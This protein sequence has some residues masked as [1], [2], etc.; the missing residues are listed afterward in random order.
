MNDSAAETSVVARLATDAA[1]ARRLSDGLAQAL[2]GGEAAVA[3]Y[4]AQGGDWTVEIHFAHPPDEDAVR[5]L[6]GELA[7]AAARERL[8]FATVAARDWVAASLAGLP[9]VQA[10]R[11]LLH[12]CHDRSR[13]PGNRVGIEIEAALA[14]GTGHHGTTRACLIALDRLLKR[15]PPRR[16]LD[17]GTGSG[18]LAIA[19][20]R[21]THRPVVAGDIDATSVTAARQNARRNR[22]GTLVSIV[23]ADG[24]ADRRLRIRMPYDLVFANILVAPLKRLAR[25]IGL[26]TAPG[27]RIVL[28]GL[29]PAE[30]NAALAAYRAAG[31]VLDRLIPL[32]GWA[33]LVMARPSRTR[34]IVTRRRRS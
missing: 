31:F 15:H 11:F 18:V 23:R 13:V 17:I 30:A 1:T 26:L 14:F 20:A 24:V 4:E 5:D 7:G 28:S 16:V 29:L 12:G 33:T 10:G 34:Q 22:A 3:A 2:D 27:A 8:V 21:A 9:P 6:I 19:A 32:D 25:P